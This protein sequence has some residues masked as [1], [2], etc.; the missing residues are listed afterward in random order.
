MGVLHT[1]RK[2]CTLD[3][4]KGEGQLLSSIIM[5]RVLGPGILGPL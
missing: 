1:L 3:A 5:K 4:D 2:Y